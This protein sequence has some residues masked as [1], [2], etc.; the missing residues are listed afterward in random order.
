MKTLVSA[1]AVALA[2]TAGTALA[3][4]GN[5]SKSQLADLGLAGMNVM[6]DAEGMQVRGMGFVRVSGSSEVELNAFL[7]F[8][9]HGVK[10][11]VKIEA[12]S[13]NDYLAIGRHRASGGSTSKIIV[14]ILSYKPI[15][16]ATGS[17]WAHAH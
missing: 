16:V 1:L 13:E 14:P 3:G 17:A 2:L 4:D 5:V 12:E 9:F 7:K 11:A 8:R 6:S 10:V 15:I